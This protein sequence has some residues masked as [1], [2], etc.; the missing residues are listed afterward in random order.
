MFIDELQTLRVRAG[1]TISKVAREADL[2]RGTVK[3]AER[4]RPARVETLYRIVNALNDLYYSERG[5]PLNPEAVIQ[6]KSRWGQKVSGVP[7]TQALT[8]ILPGLFRNHQY[9]TIANRIY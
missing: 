1:L 3:R 4:H 6:E 8:F 7:K 2:D 5:I 9:P